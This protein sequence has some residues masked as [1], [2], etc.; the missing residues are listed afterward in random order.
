[1]QSPLITV[2]TP[3]FNRASYLIRL[4]QSLVKQTFSSFEW[5]IVDDGSDDDTAEVVARLRA[6]SRMTIRYEAQP[7]S[8]KHIAINKGAVLAAGELF[9]IVDSDDIL[10]KNALSIIGSQW[11]RLQAEGKAEQYGGLCGLR[12]YTDGTVIGGDVDYQTLDASLIKYRYRMGY[13]GDKAEVFRTDLI[14]SHPFP[15][16][17][18]EKFCTE[19]LVWNR[20]GAV[21][22]FRFFNAGIYTCEYLAGGLSANSFRLRRESPQYASLYYA[23]LLNMPGVVFGHRIRAAI[24]FWR[25]ALYNKKDGVREKYRLANQP[26]SIV[27]LPV[28]Y[29]LYC[30]TKLKYK[31][32]K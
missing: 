12:T 10:P 5:L 7:N 26:W 14:R 8:G 31:T 28:G 25:F 4:Y 30:I 15:I 3:T 9:F 23:E 20:I 27:M 32:G 24:N 22:P 29:F 1:M 2:F 11:Q 13:K 6:E 17:A 16:I 18:G 19:A 21:Y